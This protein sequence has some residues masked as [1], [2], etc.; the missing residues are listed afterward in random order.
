MKWVDVTHCLA[1]DWL[2]NGETA[3]HVAARHGNRRMIAA[4][5]EEGGK[6]T[7]P[8]KVGNA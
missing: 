5:I 3:M 4:L 2:Q 1:P 8:S 7:W 6:L